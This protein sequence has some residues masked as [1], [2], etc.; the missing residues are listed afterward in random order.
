[1]RSAG[2]YA[3]VSDGDPRDAALKLAPDAVQGHNYGHSSQPPVD[4][5]SASTQNS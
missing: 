1:M 2:R 4:T 5:C 3:I